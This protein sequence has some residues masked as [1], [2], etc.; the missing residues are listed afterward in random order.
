MKHENLIEK[1][2]MKKYHMYYMNNKNKK[3]YMKCMILIFDDL[4]YK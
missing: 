1:K 4:V 3:S 2:I